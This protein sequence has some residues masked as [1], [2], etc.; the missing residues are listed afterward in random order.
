MMNVITQMRP[1]HS[2]AQKPAGFS[3]NLVFPGA[4]LLVTMIRMKTQRKIMDSFL[5]V[6]HSSPSKRF[7]KI[8]FSLATFILQGKPGVK[9]IG[10]LIFQ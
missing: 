2:P 6:I 7:S 3:S 8:L 10:P 1:C 5:N 9:I 4:Q